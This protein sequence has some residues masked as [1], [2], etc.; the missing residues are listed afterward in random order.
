MI[1]KML[2]Y[3]LIY[4]F[5]GF[6]FD[7]CDGS[8]KEAELYRKL[9][10]DYNH[11]VRP[12]R[13]P[14]KTITVT[15]KVFLQQ[16]LMVDAK[17]QMVEI[18][19]WLKYVWTD[20]RLRW[21]PVDYDNITS[22]RFEGEDQIWQPDIL[23]YNRYIEDE[24]ESFDS[25]YKTNTVVYSD[26]VINWI[27]PGNFKISCKMDIML[28][29]FDE[30]ICHMKFGSW[31]Y[32]G[33]ALDLQMDIGENAEPGADLS[34]YISNGEWHLIQAPA[35]RE[36]QF[37]KC[38]K[39]PYPTIKFYLH[40]RRRTFYYIFNVVLP[41]LLVSFM[42]LLAFCLPATDLSEKIGLQ[43]TILLSVCF[44]LT[45]LSEMTPT[46]SEAVP[47][48][49]VF[50]SALTFIIAMSTT[51]TIL[52]LNIRYRQ[53]T[54]HHMAG[55]F[56]RI[57]LDFLPW[58]MMMRRPDHKFRSCESHRIDQSNRCVQCVKNAELKGILR[59]DSETL[60]RPDALGL[61]L[62]R[63]VGDGLFI[64]KRC[65][66]HEQRRNEKFESAMKAC[67]MAIKEEA[68]DMTHILI[69]T[70]RMYESV[71]GQISRIRKR[72]VLKRRRKEIQEE[73]KFAAMAVDR[74]CLVVFSI[75]LVTCCLIFVTV[76]PIQII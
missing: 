74:F 39:E 53:I 5:V 51:F 64:Q 65:E 56:R 75:V 62:D 11:M 7:V 2:Y 29:P 72:I 33:F 13:N 1:R 54:N 26:G 67:E 55:L 60:L 30:Q 31:T 8:K 41:T 49:G 21:Q 18:N 4:F 38:C 34:T 69:T 37:F 50:F 19:A 61:K 27:P 76:P 36:E 35:M 15:M 25:T 14:K 57:F 10:K 46:T 44:F 6:G 66:I 45:I 42:S 28:F 17:H 23:L 48:L 40:L 47:L 22:V 3:I 12:V 68:N 73:W 43:T 71:V 24:Q 70:I 32:H 20:Y 58:I 52:V 16:V 9:L 59:G 63:K